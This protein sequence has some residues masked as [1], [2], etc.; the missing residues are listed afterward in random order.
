MKR[1]EL[2]LLIIMIIGSH[3]LLAQKILTLKEC[4]DRATTGNPLAGEK[5][6]YSGISKLKDEDLSKAWLPVLDANTSFLYNSDVIDMSGVFASVPIPGLSDAIKP[7]PHD[8][9]K[10]TLDINQV[11]YDGGAIKGARAIEKAELNVNEKQTDVDLY[12]IRGQIN[13]YYFSILL[14]D[15]QKDLLNIYLEILNKRL[16]SMQSALINGAILKTDIDVLS[17]EKIKIEQQLSEIEIKRTALIANL[18]DITGVHIDRGTVFIMPVQTD[19]ET[20]E[21]LRPEIQLFDL[22][23][24]QLSEG[25]KLIQSKRLPKAYGFVTLG[26]G[27]PPG[28]NFFETS[29]QPYYVFG[30]ALKWNIFDWNKVKNEKHVVTLQQ[31]IIENRKTDLTDNL[32]RLLISKKAEI[33]SLKTLLETD[34]DLIEM[35]K[36][37]TAAAESQYQNGTLTATDYLNELNTE[38]QVVVNYEIHKIHLALARIEYLNISGQE[39][40]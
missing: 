14:I 28:S 25:L 8:Q 37:I 31:D 39:I 35:R 23:K 15:S 22:R 34:N 36:R 33:A 5:I 9:Y 38:R 30:A 29:F 26:Y 40:E 1:K 27:M 21:L 2:I 24:D 11:I 16:K 17:S 7:L 18:A 4:Y 3:T 13:S 6:E 20:N 10:I 19:E 32:K 12:N